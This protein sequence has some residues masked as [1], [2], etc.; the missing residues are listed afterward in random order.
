MRAIDADKLFKEFERAAWYN[1]ADRDEIAEE[2]LLQ[3]PTITYADL[4]PHGRWEPRTDVVGFVRCS[5]CHDCN[6]YDDWPDGKKWHYCPNCGAKMDA[7]DTN[8]GD[9]DGGTNH[10]SK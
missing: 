10:D 9:K 5:V 2:M 6:I 1:N 8:V 7:T 4:V 3:M